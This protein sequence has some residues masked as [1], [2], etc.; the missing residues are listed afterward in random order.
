MD[1][2]VIMILVGDQSQF[3]KIQVKGNKLVFLEFNTAL[4]I[5]VKPVIVKNVTCGQHKSTCHD[6]VKGRLKNHL[7][8]GRG[9]LDPVDLTMV[10]FLLCGFWKHVSA[11]VAGSKHFQ[12]KKSDIVIK[13]HPVMSPYCQYV[14]AIK[15][16]FL[17]CTRKY[18]HTFRGIYF[19]L[20]LY[21]GRH[22]VFL[23]EYVFYLLSDILYINLYYYVLFLCTSYLYLIIVHSTSK[24]EKWI[25]FWYSSKYS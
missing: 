14:R 1:K 4:L 2:L 19:E 11:S 16:F 5:V 6:T 3:M 21:L 8:S 20:F 24:F 23:F 25:K 10:G 12:W 17:N 22:V 13:K 9:N 18:L 7:W 15:S